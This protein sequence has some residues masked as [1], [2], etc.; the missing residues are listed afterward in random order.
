MQ[1]T[2]WISSGCG[3]W[4]PNWSF[5]L[6]TCCSTSWLENHQESSKSTKVINHNFQ[7][8]LILFILFLCFTIASLSFKSFK[9]RETPRASFVGWSCKCHAKVAKVALRCEAC[10][11]VRCPEVS[12]CQTAVFLYW[13]WHCQRSYGGMSEWLIRSAFPAFPPYCF[14]WILLAN[15]IWSLHKVSLKV[16]R[17]L[18]SRGASTD[19]VFN[20][21]FG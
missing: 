13:K 10:E 21:T 4:R 11:A 14:D 20:L 1:N 9:G 7:W 6:E 12:T 17:C 15:P 3:W 16:Y 8:S 19:S 5:L 2:K 18:V